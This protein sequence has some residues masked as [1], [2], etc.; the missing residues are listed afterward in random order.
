[1][2]IQFYLANILYH[3]GEVLATYYQVSASIFTFWSVVRIGGLLNLLAGYSYL[4][5]SCS[6]LLPS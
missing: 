1:M 2:E 6:R 4:P 3:L 5:K